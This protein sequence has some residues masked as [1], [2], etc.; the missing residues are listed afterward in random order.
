MCSFFLIDRRK[1]HVFVIMEAFYANHPGLTMH[2]AKTM[3]SKGFKDKTFVPPLEGVINEET[4][5]QK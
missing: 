2:R 1:K 4:K 5:G 3:T